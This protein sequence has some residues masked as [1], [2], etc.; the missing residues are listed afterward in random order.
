MTQRELCSTTETLPIRVLQISTTIIA[1]IALAL[2][3]RI[4]DEVNRNTHS[5]TQISES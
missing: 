4:A 3:A 2:Q 5:H 1:M